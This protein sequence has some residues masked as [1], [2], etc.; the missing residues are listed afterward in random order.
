MNRSNA[1]Q[2]DE[3]LPDPLDG[4]LSPYLALLKQIERD[5]ELGRLRYGDRMPAHRQLA[6]HVGVSIATVTKAYH[7]AQRR[8]LV[9]GERGRGMFVNVRTSQE[10]PVQHT[11]IDLAYNLAPNVGQ[12]EA[13]YA[14]I[15]DIVTSGVR[16]ELLTFNSYHGLESQRATFS[17]WV[18]SQG[19][20]AS[21]NQL[22]I[23]SGAQQGLLIA[24]AILRATSNEP[25][26][27]EEI[28]FT[29]SRA[30]ASTLKF[31]LVPVPMD[32]FGV[33]PDAVER[34]ARETGA[35]L[36]FVNPTIQSP[37]TLTI[38]VERRR[39]IAVIIKRI[40]G[41]VV[42]DD[43]YGYLPETPIP[44]ISSFIPDN[45]VY[46][47]GFSKALT[48]GF[49]IGVMVV[50]PRF[51][52]A[53]VLAM[54]ATTWTAPALLAQAGATIVASGE[55]DRLVKLVR[56]ESKERREIFS[57]VFAHRFRQDQPQGFHA[58]L[59][60]PAGSDPN[61]I[62]VAARNSG[63]ILTPPGFAVQSETTERALRFC[64]GAPATQ[65]ELRT[66]LEIVKRLLARGEH[67]HHVL[68][69]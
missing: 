7:E 46:V 51:I 63:I 4:A 24:A 66:A 22:F 61:A 69:V 31:P 27:V 29:G 39:E 18:T 65:T 58:W 62:Y 56:Q 48:L 42:E 30:V 43:V 45:A 41:F 64:L 47:N 49:R 15:R 67:H 38:P 44:P 54:R 55:F 53:T 35:R 5:I 50:P 13:I 19:L 28:S 36:L 1:R 12:G 32:E 6:S 26:M 25:V 60:L 2:N 59:P 23:T 3:W 37:T 20:R 33:I 8:G 9:V 34:L 16:D 14:A 11:S 17:D 68:V 21:M 57:S 10:A 52:D 40:N